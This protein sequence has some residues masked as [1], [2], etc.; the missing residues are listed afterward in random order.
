MRRVLV[1]T[2][3]IA[4]FAA[5]TALGASRPAG[6]RILG[7]RAT[8]P[9]P[10][11]YTFRASGMKKPRFRCSLDAPRLQLGMH[12]AYLFERVLV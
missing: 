8:A 4:A 2:I 1:I 11:T 6:P 3:A 9:G 10:V 7:P 12:H 5:V